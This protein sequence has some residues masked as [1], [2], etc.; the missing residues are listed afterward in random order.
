[1]RIPQRLQTAVTE[2]CASARGIIHCALG[3]VGEA[4]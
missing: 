2:K 4:C 1:V 3:S